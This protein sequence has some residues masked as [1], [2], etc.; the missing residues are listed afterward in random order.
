MLTLVA[1]ALTIGLYKKK[2][3]YKHFKNQSEQYMCERELP[4]YKQKSWSETTPSFTNHEESARYGSH[5][6]T[7]PKRVTGSSIASPP[8]SLGYGSDV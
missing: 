5:S 3:D 6:Q 7:F 4:E 8:E 1:V 2:D